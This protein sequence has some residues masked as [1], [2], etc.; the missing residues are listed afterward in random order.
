MPR[1]DI[2]NEIKMRLDIVDVISE[3]V[4]LK[5][6]GSNFKGLC[7]FHSEKTPSFTVSPSKQFYY[8]FGCGEGGDLIT[9]I[10]KIENL[11]FQEAIERLARRAGID[12]KPS[13]G[14]GFNKQSTLLKILNDSAEF[15]RRSLRENP[16]ALDYLLRVRALNE[17]SIERF[18]IGYAPAAWDSLISYLRAKGYIERDMKDAGIVSYSEKGSYDLFR[19]RIIFP[20]HNLRG[21]I[22]AFGGRVMDDSLPKYINSPETVL[23][24]KAENLFGLYQAKEEIK[25]RGSVVITEG[26]L[27][28]IM[29]HQQ[30]FSNVVAP[31]G[32][33][34]TQ[35]QIALLK[36]LTE[37][38]ILLY[39]GDTAGIT[40][41]KRAIPLLLQEGIKPLIVLLPE[42]E[43]PDSFLRRNPPSDLKALLERP[44][45]LMGFYLKISGG[46]LKT[47]TVREISGAIAKIEDPL[48]RGEYIKSLAETAHLREEFLIEEVRR[49]RNTEARISATVAKKREPSKLSSVSPER[50]LMAVLFQYPQRSGILFNTLRPEDIESPEIRRLYTLA[51]SIYLENPSVFDEGDIFNEIINNLSEEDFSL[52]QIIG[53]LTFNT[54]ID[55]EALD[56]LISDCLRS[57]RL[58][59]IDRLINEARAKNDLSLLNSL[60]KE[61]MKIQRSSSAW[62]LSNNS[63]AEVGG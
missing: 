24:K 30:G 56:R 6:S 53:H 47:E 18:S 14:V 60:L 16:S 39:D 55:E 35:R 38:I 4:P 31:L 23:F 36:R 15:Y 26:Y 50:L 25:V 8:C 19:N 58:R 28:V 9:F 51:R 40:A 27:D 44:L 49:L 32:T 61:R 52:K 33:A 45:D 13:G 34:L 22:I 37:R 63:E 10:K 17:E 46:S 54:H 42:G 21:E 2:L 11:T 48:L 12:Y 5:K 59:T 3:Y 62:W 43:D 29:C 41:A 1:G 20:L 57:L 7:P